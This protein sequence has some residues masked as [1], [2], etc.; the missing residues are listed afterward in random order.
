VVCPHEPLLKFGVPCV[1]K[2]VAEHWVS[3]VDTSITV[4]LLHFVE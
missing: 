2:N 4:H 1:K 3:G